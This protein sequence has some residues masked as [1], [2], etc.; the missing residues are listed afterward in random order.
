MIHTSTDQLEGRE[1]NK[2]NGTFSVGI[3][4]HFRGL[5]FKWHYRYLCDFIATA[6]CNWYIYVTKTRTTNICYKP[7]KK[8]GS[9]DSERVKEDIYSLLV[10]QKA[11]LFSACGRL[12]RL[13]KTKADNITFFKDFAKV[14]DR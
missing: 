5:Q 13:F 11:E 14:E 2:F 12:N 7:R 8:W 3:K 6:S 9:L 1:E 4:G 10:R